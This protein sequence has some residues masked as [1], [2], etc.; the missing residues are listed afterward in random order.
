MVLDGIFDAGLI[1]LLVYLPL[2]LRPRRKKNIEV[3][4]RLYVHNRPPSA[5]GGRNE[6]LPLP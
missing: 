4:N 5:N 2:H 3:G 6:S 1:T